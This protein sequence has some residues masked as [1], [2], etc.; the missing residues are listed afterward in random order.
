MTNDSHLT[1]FLID[2]SVDQHST[3]NF[4]LNK[5]SKIISFDFESHQNLKNRRIEH[6]ISDDFLKSDDLLH[7]AKKSRYYSEW[8]LESKISD[9]LDYDGVNVGHLFNIEFHYFLVPFLKK[10]VEILRIHENYSNSN[11]VST[12]SLFPLISQF[13]KNVTKIKDQSKKDE[14]FL[15]DSFEYSFNLSGKNI[16]LH[17]PRKYYK[18]AKSSSEKIFSKMISNKISF[19]SPN[20]ILL[21]ELDTIRFENLIKEFKTS[22][23]N[24]ILYNRRRPSI[25]NKTSYNIAKESKCSI[26]TEKD[27]L[28]NNFNDLKTSGITQIQSSLNSL[29]KNEKFFESFFMIFDKSFWKPI[30]TYFIEL[31]EK[32]IVESINEIEI[33]KKLFEKLCIKAILLVSETGFNEQILVKL[34][35]KNSVPIILLQHGLTTDFENDETREFHLFVGG[36]PKLADRFISAGEIVSKYAESCNID[37]KKIE[38]LG[39]PIFDKLINIK[40]SHQDSDYIL[41]ATSSPQKNI[42]SDLT[43]ES[44]E[45]YENT[46]RQICKTIMKFNEKLIVKMHP[47]QE[48][49]DITNIVKEIEPKIPVLKS[50]DAI[51]LINNCKIFIAIDLSTT[52]LEAQILN[53]PVISISVLDKGNN[54]P[55]IFSSNSCLRSSIDNFENDLKKTLYDYKFRNDLKSKGK[56]FIANYLSNVSKSSEKIINFLENFY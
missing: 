3:D 29:W 34:A 45:N 25:W 32:R 49:L 26:L 13:S 42:A 11:F 38:T 27:F 43:I 17:I 39:S 46:I 51:S 16:K 19:D 44:I 22:N 18:F 5:N 6:Q 40:K 30:K 23:L 12:P 47:F 10:F 14:K 36:L 7:I 2:S 28:D 52:I 33:T 50:G 15:Y 8:S 35:K 41:L 31:S 53:K 48:E 9:L 56:K 24:G 55:V 37:S 1:I 54:E 20:N 4:L 21:S